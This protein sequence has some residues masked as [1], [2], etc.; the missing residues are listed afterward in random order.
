MTGIE[1][2]VTEIEKKQSFWRGFVS[3]AAWVLGA[4][5]ALC[6]AGYYFLQIVKEF[7]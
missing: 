4:Q 7:Q 6:T 2:K 5:L 1:E 3:G